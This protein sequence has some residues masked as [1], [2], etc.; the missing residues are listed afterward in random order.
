M[1]GIKLTEDQYNF[2]KLKTKQSLLSYTCNNCAPYGYESLQF[3]RGGEGTNI[4]DVWLRRQGVIVKAH[5]AL[6]NIFEKCIFETMRNTVWFREQQVILKAYT[7]IPVLRLW[8]I[9]HH[10]NL[11]IENSLE[12]SSRSWFSILNGSKV[13]IHYQN[14]KSY[15]LFLILL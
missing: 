7:F 9:C 15:S 10:G 3:P 12:K 14:L 5:I 8:T 6:R 1:L 13:K 11:K 2:T 4:A